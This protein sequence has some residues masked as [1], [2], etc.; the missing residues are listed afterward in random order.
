MALFSFGKKCQFV[1][2]ALVIGQMSEFLSTVIKSCCDKSFSQYKFSSKN[3]NF[4]WKKGNLR[5]NVEFSIKFPLLLKV[6]KNWHFSKTEN[7][8][9]RKLNI[10]TRNEHFW[11]QW[12]F[13]IEKWKYPSLLAFLQDFCFY[14]WNTHNEKIDTKRIVIF[15]KNWQINYFWN[16][17]SLFS[18]LTSKLTPFSKKLLDL[19]KEFMPPEM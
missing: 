11:K 2:N 9:L 3:V 5:R 18:R 10:S 17:L 7:T 8:S 1:Q 16:Q 19:S 13:P 6:I 15:F 4:V 12:P 14:Q